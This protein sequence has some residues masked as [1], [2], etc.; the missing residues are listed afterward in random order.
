MLIVF[1]FLALVLSILFTIDPTNLKISCSGI[2]EKRDQTSI[3]VCENHTSSLINTEKTLNGA[4][5]KFY[6]GDDVNTIATGLQLSK[7][8]PTFYK[9]QCQQM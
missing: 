7:P 1:L 2:S 6:N 4:I 3:T 9:K 5:T 8:R